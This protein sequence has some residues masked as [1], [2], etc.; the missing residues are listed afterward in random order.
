LELLPNLIF[1]SVKL[2]L[3]I[4]L[5][6]TARNSIF[7]SRYPG[8]Y[9]YQDTGVTDIS[10]QVTI[11][12]HYE[13][14]FV[15]R[16]PLAEAPRDIPE[17]TRYRPGYPVVPWHT[18]SS[19]PITFQKEW[20]AMGQVSPAFFFQTVPCPCLSAS[21]SRLCFAE[22]LLLIATLTHPHSHA[23]LHHVR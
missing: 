18:R 23:S 11:T 2:K 3:D 15:A 1:A 21:R 10:N 19:L 6:P 16:P 13:M 9:G 22:S 12:V 14:D 4:G 17:F 7:T 5:T 20:Q 8:P